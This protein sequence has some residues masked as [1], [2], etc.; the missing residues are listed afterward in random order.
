[1]VYVSQYAVV[2]VLVD[3]VIDV[4]VISVLLPVPVFNDHVV[5]LV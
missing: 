4:N 5:Q 3:A 2:N 1:M